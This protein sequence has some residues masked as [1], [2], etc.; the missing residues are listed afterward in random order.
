MKLALSAALAGVCLSAA[1]ERIELR[2][3]Y[4]SCVVETEGARFLS[5]RPADG[6]YCR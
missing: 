6:G 5:F 1:A 2:T 4:A 3:D